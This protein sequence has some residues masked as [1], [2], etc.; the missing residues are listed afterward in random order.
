MNTTNE[1]YKGLQNSDSTKKKF[2]KLNNCS[3]S[4][5]TEIISFGRV[6]VN[7]AHKESRFGSFN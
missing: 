1:R 5:A 2:H 7:A 4:I 3:I 6:I